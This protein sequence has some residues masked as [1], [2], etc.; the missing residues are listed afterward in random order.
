MAVKLV[1]LPYY[2]DSSSIFSNIADEPWSVFLD[3]GFPFKD[4]GRYDIFS[5]RPSATFI[6]YGRETHI[7]KNDQQHTSTED[8]FTLIRI[9]LGE[10][11]TNHTALPFIG[12]ALGYFAYDLARVIEDL[13]VHSSHDLQIPDMA[14][15]LY[16]WAV[17]VDHQLRQSWLTSHDH[18]SIDH[19]EWNEL[20]NLFDGPLKKQYSPFKAVST[21]HS[22]FDEAAYTQAF[23]KIKHYITEGDCYQVN[24]AQRFNVRVEGSAWSAYKLLRELNP[25]QFASYINIPECKIL[26]SSPE[27]FLK[28]KSG[29][30][31][32]KP[33]KGTRRRSVF[34]YE[35]TALAQEL[36]ESEKDR[37]ENVMIVDLLRN[38]LGKT[39]LT[40]SISVP[41]LYA[42][43]SYAT[44][45]H[46]VS[47]VTG[48]LDNSTHALDLLRGCF[49]GGSI[50]GA[51]K[52]RS[53]EII[54]ELEPNR[55]NVYCGSI[56]YIG[57]DGDMD[58]NIAIRTMVHVD[59]TLYC[60]AGGGIVH[61]SK[62][63]A[64]YQES[65]DKA[66][67]MLKLFSMKSH[68]S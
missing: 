39:C 27:R 13:P 36:L 2:K 24:L 48:R 25:A 53:M 8:P 40:G 28:L 9:A 38:D 5:S 20:L 16:D 37:A 41:K 1:E 10:K 66:E 67:A 46:L 52:L 31:E 65:F 45:H 26:S 4:T 35:D 42:L 59:D 21:T 34:A 6:N 19:E 12:G 15:G 54:E 32:T 43:E 11:R 17:V 58:T 29:L 33:I 50:T 14:I 55:R 60:W 44:V 18:Q 62:A 3:S 47:T 57:Y 68:I 63:Q 23:N 30:V 64:E 22:N 51:P 49:P 7:Q 61:D 56:G